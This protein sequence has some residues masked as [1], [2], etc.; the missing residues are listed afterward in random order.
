MFNNRNYICEEIKDATPQIMR[1]GNKKVRCYFNSRFGKIEI[2]CAKWKEN[3]FF[4]FNF[5]DGGG[6][7]SN[8]SYLTLVAKDMKII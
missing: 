3:I 8:L 4:Y 7:A 6:I 2:F 5:G 1:W